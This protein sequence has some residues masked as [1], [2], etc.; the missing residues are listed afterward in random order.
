MDRRT[1]LAAMTLLLVAVAALPALAVDVT[2]PV[3]SGGPHDFRSK[4][5]Y[6]GA[7][8][9]TNSSE[10]CKA[11]HIPHQALQDKYLWARNYNLLDTAPGALSTDLCMGCH[12]GQMAAN[13]FPPGVTL[14]AAVTV[15]PGVG[16]GSH[17][18]GANAVYSAQNAGLRQP[19]PLS[20]YLEDNQ[21]TCGTCHDPHGTQ[22]MLRVPNDNS[23]LCV[24]C[25]L[26]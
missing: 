15:N 8:G 21:V 5:D 26:K 13:A 16:G 17:P 25:H 2:Q 20:T 4:S 19:C 14:P 3:M 10:I 12:D 24:T 22:S 1:C 7:T 6:A 23:A 18:V 11:C 9:L